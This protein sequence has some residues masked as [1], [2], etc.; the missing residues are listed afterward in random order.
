M[1][2]QEYMTSNLLH[3]NLDKCCFMYF[4]PRNKFLKTQVYDKNTRNDRN[5]KSPTQKKKNTVKPNIANSG[6]S[7]FINQNP[8]KETVE[9]RFLGVIFDPLLNWNTHITELN[10][11][12]QVSFA[13][14]KRITPYIPDKNYKNL[15]HTLF[16]PHLGYC[17]SVW[18]SARRKLIEPLF[19]LQKSDP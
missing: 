10:K 9:A 12:L 14:L 17:I 8:I 19:T 15:Y 18:G 16:E 7:L 1:R 11:K 13:I 5:K 6:I 2:V 4:P 3:I